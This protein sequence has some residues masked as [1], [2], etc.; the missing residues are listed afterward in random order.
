M[1]N[2][3][4]VSMN[5]EST[6]P[7]ASSGQQVMTEPNQRAKSNLAGL[8]GR[9]ADHSSARLPLLWARCN[10]C[11]CFGK[12]FWGSI[13]HRSFLKAILLFSTRIVKASKSEILINSENL[14]TWKWGSSGQPPPIEV[15][16][17]SV[18]LYQCVTTGS[19]TVTWGWPGDTLLTRS[20]TMK[21]K[22]VFFPLWS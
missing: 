22:T 9:E 16:L 11:C 8:R 2:P 4:N 14:T 17:T 18:P 13:T 20:N 3:E 12:C 7:Q 6:L 21:R 1:S 10:V 19:F 15:N 5:P